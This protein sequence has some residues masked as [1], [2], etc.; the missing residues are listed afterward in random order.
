MRFI[1][2]IKS[3]YYHLKSQP[4]LTWISISGT[5]LAIFLI[6]TV[7]ML[8]EVMTAP[9]APESSRD[10]LLYYS[11]ISVKYPDGAESNCPMSWQFI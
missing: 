4:L 3:S 8:Q 9:F 5:A 1:Q 7:V 2:L 10:R 11:Y 6:M